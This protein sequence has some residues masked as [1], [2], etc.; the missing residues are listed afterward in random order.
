MEYKRNLR[1]FLVSALFVV[2]ACQLASSGPETEIAQT[3]VQISNTAPTVGTVT[4]TSPLTLS[5]YTTV[6]VTCSATVT[7]V[8]GWE[9]VSSSSGVFHLYSVGGGCTPDNADCY[10]NNSCELSGGSSTT[11]TSTCSFTVYWYAQ[12]SS[13]EG[14]WTCAITAVD[15]GANSGTNSSN[16]T[17]S[18]LV[19]LNITTP[20]AF[21]NMIVGQT[22]AADVTDTVSNTGN[23]RFDIN[24]N[25][26][27]MTCDSGSIA[28]GY[29]HYNISSGIDYASMTPLTADPGDTAV[30]FSTNFNLVEGA[31][32]SDDTYWKIQIPTGVL[33]S[34]T[35]TVQF[36]AIKG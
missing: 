19:A 21:G 30:E 22:S 8:N 29:I 23:V 17:V 6:V 32:S 27:D 35:G 12:A 3:T 33:G 36:E 24:V 16:T 34:C 11:V 25:G 15:S 5:E 7:D 2:M 1:I 18:D 20:I 13:D 10:V 14:N 26:T 9:D 4:P 31:A 28:V